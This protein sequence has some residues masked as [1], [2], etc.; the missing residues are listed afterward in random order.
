MN[1]P[2]IAMKKLEMLL[3]AW[4]EQDP[5][6][7]AYFAACK[8]IVC[9]LETTA[10]ESNRSGYTRE[11]LTKLNWSIDAMFGADMDNGHGF[12]SHKSWAIGE[13]SSLCSNLCFGSANSE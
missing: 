12:A 10:S 11:K 4:N 13:I 3:L 6:A 5:M 1:D 2:L 7:T 9:D 8:V